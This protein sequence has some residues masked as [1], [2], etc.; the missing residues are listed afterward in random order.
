MSD[1]IQIIDEDKGLTLQERPI[2]ISDERLN[3][4]LK[5]VYERARKDERGVKLYDYY[6]IVWSS[7][8]TLFLTILSQFFTIDFLSEQ[9]SGC[10]WVFVIECVVDIVLLVGAI[11]VTIVRMNKKISD[12]MSERDTVVA[13]CLNRHYNCATKG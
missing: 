9:W 8:F 6:G 12:M 2:R 13:E 5:E 1:P 7:F 4:I 11:I 10:Q 3:T